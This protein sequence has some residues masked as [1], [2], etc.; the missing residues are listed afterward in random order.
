MTWAD[1]DGDWAP[2][3]IS[4]QWGDAVWAMWKVDAKSFQ[5]QRIQ[6]GGGVRLCWRQ[7]SCI[8]G[9]ANRLAHPR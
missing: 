1:A 8:A 7:E 9:D 3:R 4:E 6:K 2:V 5:K